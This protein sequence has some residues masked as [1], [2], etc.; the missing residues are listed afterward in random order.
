MR[1]ELS[2]W[3]LILLMITG[4][5]SLGYVA[6]A[7]SIDCDKAVREQT[8]TPNQGHYEVC[9]EIQKPANSPLNRPNRA[10]VESSVCEEGYGCH[11]IDGDGNIDQS[12]WW[13][14]NTVRGVL[15]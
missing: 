8:G 7:D 4:L 2:F 5:M 14:Y 1:K 10:V 13:S 9:I 12:K 6:H 3:L 11:P 15:A